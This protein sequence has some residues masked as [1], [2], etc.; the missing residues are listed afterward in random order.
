MP[1]QPGGSLAG[2]LSSEAS[3]TLLSA[4]TGRFVAVAGG[5][6]LERVFIKA[7]TRR[8]YCT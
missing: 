7:A 5:R 3:S 4:A 8:N 1:L 2:K 6:S